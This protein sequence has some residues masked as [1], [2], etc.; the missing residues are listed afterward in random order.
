MI[1]L[2]VTLCLGLAAL[3]PALALAQTVEIEH[4][5]V[6]CIVVGKYP[7]MNAC[8]TPAANLARA[9]VYFRPEGV[10]SWYYVEMKSDQPCFAGTLPKPGKKLVGKKIE[11]YVEGQDK[12]FNAGRTAEFDPIVVRSAQECKKNVPVAPFLNNATVAVFP[13][14]PAGFVGGGLGT[15]AIVGI[16]G[17]GAAAAGTAAVVASNNNDTT[18][19]TIAIGGNTTTTIAAVTTTTTT[20]TTVPKVNHAPSIVLTTSP[21]PATG[22][23]PLNVTFDTCQSKDPDGDPLSFFFDFG[24]G[25]TS[26]GSCNVSHTYPQAPF[27]ESSNVRAATVTYN[28]SGSVV[29]PSGASATKE[30][31]V[32]VE[33]GRSGGCPKLT[34]SFATP[35]GFV[36]C[37]PTVGVSASSNGSRVSFC[38]SVASSCYPSVAGGSVGSSAASPP[39]GTTCVN[40]SRSGSSFTA[41]LPLSS[42]FTC[43]AVSAQAFDECG[44][45]EIAGPAFVFGGSCYYRG[46]GALRKDG[47]R[48]TVWSSE[49]SL[50]GRLQV[51]VNGASPAFPGSG[52]GFGTARLADGENRVEA[53]VVESA[54]KA[55][56]WRID[57]KPSEAILAGS[58]RVI[59]GEIVQLGPASATFRLS[60]KQGERIVFT[61]LKK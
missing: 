51:V 50:E 48:T 46:F 59:S 5:A 53:V 36:G 20:T 27:R 14:V 52:R 7:K 19:T 24:D 16:A 57:L 26:S 30:K 22:Q 18:T 6:G 29:D 28:A 3:M 45:N 60:G 42:G 41:D 13:A 47:G 12:T 61:F 23:G 38:S 11:Y 8:F 55:G 34:L 10:P 9:R 40:G 32:T 44:A 39:G 2:R 54:G 33:S 56:L 31:K 35:P 58:L 25:A 43:Y 49:L 1:R 17:A 21:D 4:K 37:S 15:A